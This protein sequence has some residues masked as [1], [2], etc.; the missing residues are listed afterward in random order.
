MDVR[1]R[2]TS[3]DSA[4]MSKRYS[5]ICLETQTTRGPEVAPLPAQAV[6]TAATPQATRRRRRTER[7]IEWVGSETV[8]CRTAGKSWPAPDV[9][10]RGAVLKEV[11]RRASHGGLPRRR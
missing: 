11:R 4:W 6:R 8:A 1:S 5:L 7:L 9:L 10:Y 2:A 3:T